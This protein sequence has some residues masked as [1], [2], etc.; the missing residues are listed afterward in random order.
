MLDQRPDPEA[1]LKRAHEEEQQEQ[2]GKLKIY[3]GAAPGVGKTYTMVKDALALRAQGIDVVVG[4]VESH[5]R[6][7]IE[8]LLKDLEILPRQQINYRGIEL[9]EFDLDGALKRNPTIILIDE[10]AHTNVPGLRHEK[11][12][13]DINE[14]LDR[15]INVYTTL[16]VQHVESLNDI[17]AQITGIIVRETIPD[18]V[19]EQAAAIELIDLPPEDLLKRLEEGKIYLPKQAEYATQNFFRK[20]NLIALRELA[21]RITAEQVNSQVFLHRKG[22]AIQRIWPTVERL[23]VCIGPN[24]SSAKLI[25]ST[26]RMAR[27]LKAEWIAVFVE[28]P[29]L[30]L[31][32]TQRENALQYLRLA[33]QLGGETITLTG[34]DLVQEITSFARLRNVTKIII[35]KQIRP[36]WKTLL[37][38]SVVDELIRHI[39]EIELYIIHGETNGAKPPKISMSFSPYAKWSDYLR[40]IMTVAACTGVNELLYPFFWQCNL[41]MVYMLGVIYVATLG[42]FFPSLLTSVLSAFS[43]AYFYLPP[44]FSFALT[45][46]QYLTSVLVTL[47]VA[48]LISSLT[49]KSQQQIEEARIREIR[50]ATMYILSRRLAN[51]RGINNLLQVAA[52]HIKEIFD[53][54]VQI[55]LPNQNKHLEVCG[56][57]PSKIKLTS[58][59]QSVAQWVYDLGQIAGLGTQTLPDSDSI[60][61]PLLGSHGT[62]GV[63]RVKPKDPDELKTPEQLHLLE[64]FANQTALAIEVDLLEEESKKT[65]L[66]TEADR[67]R[68]VLLKSVSHNL[69]IPLLEMLESENKLLSSNVCGKY[70]VLHEEVIKISRHTQQLNSLISNLLQMTQLESGKLKLK[71]ELHSMKEIIDKALYILGDEIG[72]RTVNVH[73]PPGL[74][75][76]Y[77]EPVL[78]EQVF[79]QLIDN[80]IKYSSA[81]SSID[82]SV[83]SDENNVI[84]E[85]ENQGEGLTSEEMKKVFDRFYRGRTSKVGMG[86]GL[87]ISQIIIR[88]HGGLIWAEN[89]DGGG[90][91]FCFTLPRKN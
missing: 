67:I 47:M 35:G 11:R 13:Q 20:G 45:D 46:I 23:M 72:Q 33:E 38:G 54:E 36:R 84:V 12:W 58:K 90:V 61:I 66:Q 62:V 82:V 17:V 30:H 52:D 25:R 26:Y 85:I 39:G 10:M 9:T 64:S 60:Y 86:L 14:L 22:E 43:F 87:T 48:Q 69:R 42:R 63:I 4:V 28:A 2:R 75:D 15:G 19:L 79:I 70:P 88:A 34:K 1:F 50:T 68:G 37:F 49:V 65:A 59:E 83:S 29:R 77:F 40:A 27:S 6:K 91:I 57:H 3:F 32:K 78:L 51:A 53:C 76:I 80:A 74:P 24:A 81:E 21:L 56:D 55:L 7:E 18:L 89:R 44:R 41:V 8:A 71:K 31:S 73:M 5:G 16:N